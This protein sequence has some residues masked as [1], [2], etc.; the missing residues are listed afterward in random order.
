MTYDYNKNFGLFKF[1]SGYKKFCLN[2][3]KGYIV[4][5]YLARRL[6]LEHTAL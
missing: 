2:S 1:K 4:E 5:R 3:P 6:M